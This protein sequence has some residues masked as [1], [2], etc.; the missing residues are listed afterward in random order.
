MLQRL[1]QLKDG[2]KLGAFFYTTCNH[3][4]HEYYRQESRTVP[5]DE[6]SDI[7]AAGLDPDDELD[8]KYA[9]ECVRE[10]LAT[11]PPRD[12]EILRAVLMEEE[13]RD[14]ICARFGIEP[15]YLRVLLLR[16]KE[17][18]REAWRR[19]RPRR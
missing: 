11:L 15:S 4:V 1:E 3:V 9:A 18:F 12:G 8:R 10:V 5:L 17:K 2:R 7:A 19:R 6:K 13:D 16:A 14:A